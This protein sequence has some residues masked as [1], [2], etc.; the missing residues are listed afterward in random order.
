M[1]AVPQ[2]LA[3]TAAFAREVVMP[4]AP[5][6]EAEQRIGREAVEAAA[7]I[8]LTG[9]EVPESWGGLGDQ[10]GLGIGQRHGRLGRGWTGA[11]MLSRPPPH[12]L[13]PR[14]PPRP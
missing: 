1:T 7:A 13:A 6:W 9:L 5:R 8:G 11:A 2:L 3:R 4:G 12:N 10:G 14:R